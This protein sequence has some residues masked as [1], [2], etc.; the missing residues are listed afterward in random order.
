MKNT[1]VYFSSCALDSAGTP[2]PFM[3]QELPWLL[4]HFDRVVICSYYGVAEITDPRPQTIQVATPAHGAWRARLRAPFSRLFWQELL[5]LAKDRKLT[6]VNALRLLLFTLRGYKLY[7]WTRAVLRKDEHVTFYSLWMSYDGFAAALCKRKRPDARALARGHAFD[8]DRAR[9][10]LNPYY[11]K[12]FMAGTLD[13]VYPI[14]EDAKR[15]LLDCVPVPQEKLHV[16][17]MGSIGEMADTRLDPPL[18]D[19]G[20]FH[21]VSCS[22]VIAIKQ[23]PLLIDALAAWP[24]ESRVSWLHIG[25]GAEEAAVRTYATQKLGSL[26]HVQWEITGNVPREQVAA[27]YASRPLDVFV[28]TSRSEGVPVSIMEA[29]RAGLPVVAP[30]V[31]GIPEIVDDSFGRLYDPQG[32]FL[33]VRDVLLIFSRMQR[34]DALAMRS[35]AQT[36]WNQHWRSEAL[37]ETLFPQAVK[38]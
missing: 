18:Y 32:G 2:D 33:A 38:E 13:G 26:P 30:R 22:S 14:S 20:V 34:E 19:T 27:L 6:P 10:P 36:C 8:I 35:A 15:K 4:S 9:D 11:M 16:L 12:R 37:L 23:L 24:Q 7:Y 31:G 29:M 3:L 17:A 25:G 5:R 1:L 21:I 28:N